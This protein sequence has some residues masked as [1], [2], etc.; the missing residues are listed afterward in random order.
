[1]SLGIISRIRSVPV[2]ARP[3]AFSTMK[4]RGL[5]SKENRNYPLGFLLSLG[6]I[7]I[8]PFRSVLWKSD[9]IEPIY[10]PL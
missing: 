6:Y 4:A 5:A 3:P 8:P 10:L 9:T 2:E 7:N 1:M